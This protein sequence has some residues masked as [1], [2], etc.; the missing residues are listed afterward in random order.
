MRVRPGRARACLRLLTLAAV[1]ATAL[2][3][4]QPAA[5]AQDQQG[6]HRE[7]RIEEIIVTAQKRAENV[8]DVPASITALSGEALAAT[9]TEEF[10]DYAAHVPSLSFVDLGSPGRQII[11]LRGVSSGL[12]QATPTVG[13][14]LD[15]TPF[16]SRSAALNL[17]LDLYDIDRVEVLRG[18]QG[19]LYGASSLGGLIKLVTRKPDLERVEGS[20]EVTLSDTKGGSLNTKVAGMVNVPLI[21][22][23]LALRAVAYQRNNDGF[24]DNVTLGQENVNDN[25]VTG[26]RLSLLAAAG[27]RLSLQTTL[28]FQRGVTNGLNAID[29]DASQRPLFGDLT[30]D[31]LTEEDW[32]L[33]Y[34]LANLTA[35]YDLDWASLLSS[36][37]FSTIDSSN[38][39]DFSPFLLRPLG[40]AVGS[41]TAGDNEVFTQE[42]RLSGDRDALR[43]IVGGFFTRESGKTNQS[44]WAFPGPSGDPVPAAF[45]PLLNDD[46]G[47]RYREWAVFG[48]ATYEI[49]PD[50]SVIL[51]GRYSRNRQRATDALNGFLVNGADPLAVEQTTGRS[52]DASTT[53]RAGINYRPVPNVLT[54]AQ[55]SQ[56]Y[57]TG[58]PNNAAPPDPVTGERAPPSY[59]PDQLWNYEIGA[60]TEWLDRRLILDASAFLIDWDDIQLRA[61][62]SDGFTFTGNAGKARSRG[63]ELETALQATDALLL[64]LNGSWVEAE[65]RTD[66]ASLGARRGDRLPGVPQWTLGARTELALG[67]IGAFEGRLNAS[68]RYTGDRS[69]SY[70]LN[71][72]RPQAPLHS[73]DIVDLRATFSR[74]ALEIALFADNLFDTRADLNNDTVFVTRG[75]KTTNRPRTLGVTLRAGF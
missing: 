48:D 49:L 31:R 17:D 5:Y 69:T 41:V 44:L 18:P 15:E 20:G 1:Q 66:V 53:T 14:Y 10:A 59:K 40:V 67:R 56:G 4:L 51:G 2:T 65:I 61:R 28:L 23:T 38:T 22:D 70:A 24:I 19:T 34:M 57:R 62:R 13:I 68:Y 72:A 3:S 7:P 52:N 42:V 29:L 71:V 30:Q 36:T 75:L 16:G 39:R 35:T 58:G 45:D 6:A 74:D 32:A 9:G 50:L 54:Y 55:A 47:T 25:V 46:I 60:K 26:G 8:R 12:D 43:W 63:V 11:T 73:Y 64:A 27:E 37:N 33:T 21:E